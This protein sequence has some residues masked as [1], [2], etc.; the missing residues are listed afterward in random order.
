MQT[1]ID[2]SGIYRISI[3]VPDIASPAGFTFSHFLIVGDEPPLFHC[4]R[5]KMFP[6]VCKAVAKVIPC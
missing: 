1:G 2:S 3:F 5:R 6:L 4:G